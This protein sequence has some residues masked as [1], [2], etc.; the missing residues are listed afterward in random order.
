MISR[1]AI[2]SA[3]PECILSLT[4]KVF[5]I[6]HGEALD[7]IEDRYGG[8]YDPD[9]SPAGYEGAVG[10]GKK[11]KEMN[12]GAKLILSSPL[13]RA[14][15]TA[16]KISEVLKIPVEIFVYLKERNTYGLLCG[17]NKD[18]AKQKYP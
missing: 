9:L 8:W 18:E 6:R 11:L 2:S 7:D 12:T 5:F 13:K 1:N 15:Q 16:S 17:E 10:V 3:F 14:V 4:M